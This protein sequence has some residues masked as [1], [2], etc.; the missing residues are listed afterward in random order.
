MT[1]LGILSIQVCFESSKEGK[2]RS[3]VDGREKIKVPDDLGRIISL[4]GDTSKIYL[5]FMIKGVAKYKLSMLRIE[6]IA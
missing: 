6:H 5:K 3:C 1:S 2:L 4:R